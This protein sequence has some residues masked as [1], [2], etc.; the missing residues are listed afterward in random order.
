MIMKKG[1]EL[2]KDFFDIMGKVVIVIGVIGGFGSI[3][4]MVL[5]MVG[6]K[7]MVIG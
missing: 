1:D 5:V 3:I 2:L 4:S 6:V 7:V